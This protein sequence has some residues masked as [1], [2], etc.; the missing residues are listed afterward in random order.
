MTE[1]TP[2]FEPIIDKKDQYEHLKASLLPN[3]VIEAVLDLKN[4]GTGFLG[5][6]TK[7]I[8]FY[9]P[10]FLRKIKAI[11]SVPYSRIHVI[12]THDEAGLFSGQG[13]FASSKLT[14]AAS[15]GD[16]EFEFR[17]ADKAHVAHNLILSHMV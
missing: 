7:R 9:D 2:A 15:N 14:L 5:I 3:E 10:T 16:Y 11:V 8:V 1:A 17:G 4:V 13:F 6:T 12:A